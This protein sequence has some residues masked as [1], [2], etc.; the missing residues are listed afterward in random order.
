MERTDFQHLLFQTAFC[1]VASDGHIDDREVEELRSLEGSAVY[2]EGID[3]QDDLDQFVQA[4]E[5]S[6]EDNRGPVPE[7]LDKIEASDLT[8]VQELLLIEVALRILHADEKIHAK[9]VRLVRQMR[10]RLSVNDEILLERFGP[11]N[12]LFD[13]EYHIPESGPDIAQL[14]ADSSVLDLAETHITSR[15]NDSEESGGDGSKPEIDP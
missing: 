7:L 3:L 15:F 4:L 13:S 10:N 6:Q 2:F 9:E 1:V 8:V 14:L 11:S 5:Q 12:A